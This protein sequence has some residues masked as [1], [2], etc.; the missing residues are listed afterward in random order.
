[1]EIGVTNTATEVDP[2]QAPLSGKVL[3]TSDEEA[4]VPNPLGHMGTPTIT[5]EHSDQGQTTSVGGT[6]TTALRL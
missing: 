1:M 3:D 6:E 2:S 4:P 5:W